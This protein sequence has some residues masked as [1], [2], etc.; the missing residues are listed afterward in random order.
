MISKQKI[1]PDLLNE[2]IHSEAGYRILYQGCPVPGLL[3]AQHLRQ[4]E[5]DIFFL[6]RQRIDIGEPV[7]I[8]PVRH[9]VDQN[10]GG[11]GAGGN[12]HDRTR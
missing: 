11:R 1:T 9:P 7:L 6:H 12:A 3:R 10:F 2:S 8:Q 5:G 4:G